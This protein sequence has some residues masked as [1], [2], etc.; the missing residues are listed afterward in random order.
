MAEAVKF[1]QLRRELCDAYEAFTEAAQKVVDSGQ[2]VT[3]ENCTEWL[4]W[5]YA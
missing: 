2:F 4:R 1:I 3:V 5:S